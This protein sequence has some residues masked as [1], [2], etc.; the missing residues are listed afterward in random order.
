MKKIVSLM[1]VIG[2]LLNYM[3]LSCWW[4]VSGVIFY[5][6]KTDHWFHWSYKSI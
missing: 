2:K 5:W 3:H 4:F 1:P 6:S